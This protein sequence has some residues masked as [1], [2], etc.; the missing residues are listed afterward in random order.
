MHLESQVPGLELKPISRQLGLVMRVGKCEFR[1]HLVS[2]RSEQQQFADR[3]FDTCEAHT[4]RALLDSSCSRLYQFFYFFFIEKNCNSRIEVSL[5]LS[6]DL[7]A[8]FCSS[9]ASLSR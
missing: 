8:R 5:Y 4:D 7:L 6:C 2:P 9:S 3:E 1:Q